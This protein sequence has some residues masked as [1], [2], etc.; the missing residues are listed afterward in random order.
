MRSEL[1]LRSCG[2]PGAWN[3]LDILSLVSAAAAGA[4]NGGAGFG[5]GAGG[6]GGGSNDD[7]DDGAARTA[8]LAGPVARHTRGLT[9]YVFIPWEGVREHVL[10]LPA[11]E[12]D[13]FFPG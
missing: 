1:R 3:R 2:A 6:A 13:Y 12:L 7:G 5:S 8:R 9:T 4:G 11:E 10:N